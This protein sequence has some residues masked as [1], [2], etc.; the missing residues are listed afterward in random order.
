MIVI[1]ASRWDS[2]AAACALRW[3]AH[4][5]RVLTAQDLSVGGWRQRLHGVNGDTAIVDGETVP[6][7]Q[8]TGVLTLLRG[9]SAEE[10]VDIT[11]RDRVYVA[12]EMTAF[13]LL[14]L[15]RL[16][17]PILNRPTPACLSGPNWRREKWVRVAVQAGI[18][19]LPVRRL[20]A[21]ESSGAGEESEG[22]AVG[23]TVVGPRTFGEVDP[24][25]HRRA[26][27]LADLARVELVQI[28]FSGPQSDA[29]F[30]A[31]DTFPSLTHDWLADAALGYL[32]GGVAVP[33]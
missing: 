13:L 29:C 25:L 14:W 3:A 7:Q 19:V 17:C 16:T 6:Q 28:R 11:P 33:A 10:L 4:D 24:A 26:R 32:R 27:L 5:V 9:V 21:F 12:A 23:V 2:T 22:A 8:I 20:V 30:I 1:V 15:S 31:A 18:P